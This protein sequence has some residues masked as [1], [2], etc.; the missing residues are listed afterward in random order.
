MF[1]QQKLDHDVHLSLKS[2]MDSSWCLAG[3]SHT[4]PEHLFLGFNL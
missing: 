4:R 2:L 1:V 3:L